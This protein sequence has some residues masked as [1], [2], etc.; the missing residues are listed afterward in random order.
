V[1]DKLKK[2]QIV[3]VEPQSSENIGSV[4]RAMKT[5]GISNLV[6]IGT[7]IYDPHRIKKLS[8]NSF[9]IYENS[10]RYNN[11]KS[12]L[13]NSVLIAGTTRRSGKNRKYISIYPEELANK[14]NLIESG[15]ISI[16]FGRESSGLT[17]QEL[18]E[19]NIAVTIPS[20]PDSPS[21][22][23]AQAVQVISYSIY[24]S[25]FTGKGY[26][27]V[28]S[29]RMEEVIETVSV[30]LGKLDFFKKN[31]KN[32]L[33]SFFSDIFSRAGISQIESLRI[34]RTIKKLVG[35]KNNKN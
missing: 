4:C 27:P 31:E 7:T 8:V 33:K 12:A 6:I 17:D 35:I 16:V 3:L 2:I 15:E 14:I 26:I 25:G 29:K 28:D 34:E 5:M 19:C 18:K 24:R 23:L 9:D 1:K 21:L 11:L 30:S 10:K 20:S 32:E 22:N 13:G